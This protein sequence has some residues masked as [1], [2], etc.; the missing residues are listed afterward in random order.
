VAGFAGQF[1]TS[2]VTAAG[3]RDEF[4]RVAGETRTCIN[5]IDS[6][7]RSTEFLE[8][9]VTVAPEDL[10]ALIRRFT[11]LLPGVDVVTLS[12]SAPSGC[13]T[14]VYVPLIRAAA[15]AGKPVLLDTSGSL[16]AAGV[17][18]G[19][20]VVK[21]NQ[22]E[23]SALIGSELHDRDEVMVAARTMCLQGPEWVVVSLGEWGAVAVSR[24]RA[25]EVAAP[26]V[27]ALNTVG[28]GD[29][30]VGGL[31]TGLA[32]GLDV[33]EALPLAV[34][35]SAAAAAHPETGVFDPAFAAGLETHVTVTNF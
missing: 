28:C 3:M 10:S 9:G 22:E 6:A 31:A 16:L 12:G 1:V 21:P 18:A 35:V 7:G 14:D 30:L 25:V 2:Q 26:R 8:P 19:P 24:D 33:A 15:A 5:I 27:T 4:V 13:P 34:R 11:E 20:T 17:A 32:S 29:V 23:L